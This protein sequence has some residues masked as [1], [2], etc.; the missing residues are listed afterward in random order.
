MGSILPSSHSP[1]PPPPPPHSPPLPATV[2]FSQ[3]VSELPERLPSVQEIEDSPHVLKKLW[4]ER[5]VRVGQHYVAKYGEIT[6]PIEGE[7]MIFARE[8]LKSVVPRLFAIY[9]RP[10]RR[11][12]EPAITYLIMEYID[13]PPLSE[14]WDTMGEPERIRVVDSLHGTLQIIRNIPPPDYFGGL[15]MA[16]FNDDIFSDEDDPPEAGYGPFKTESELINALVSRYRSK[17]GDRLRHAADYYQRVLPHVL[18]GSG[19]PVF[20]HGDLQPKNI[21]I[22]TRGKV[23][24]IDWEASGWYPIW[25][26]YATTMDAS[27]LKDDWHNYVPRCMSEFPNHFAWFNMLYREMWF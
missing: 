1:P 24:I 5:V 27:N 3:P 10:R 26:E 18:Q 21:M 9:Q 19:K 6:R 14:V 17:A 22:G 16:K 2:L 7:N 13:G 4:S 8:H 11:K 12:R 15:G 23:M 20:T 25:W